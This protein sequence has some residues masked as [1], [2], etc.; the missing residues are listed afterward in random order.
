[1]WHEIWVQKG[2]PRHGYIANIRRKTR[3]K[4]HYA[5]RYVVKENI[6]IRNKKLAEAVSE[7]NDRV[8]W[9]EV[10]KMSKTNKEL[11]TMMDS[12]SSIEEITDIFADKYKILYNTV[13]YDAQDLNRL[14][15]DIDSRIENGFLNATNVNNHSHIVK[16]QEVKDAIYKLKQGKKEE[17]G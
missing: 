4:Y 2:R 12:L 1:M 7:N 13:S 9:E 17:N 8:L 5:I 10:R 3:L 6:K 16:V 11:P 14:T 15:A